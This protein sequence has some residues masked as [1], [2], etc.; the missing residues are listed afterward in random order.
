M[1]PGMSDGGHLSWGGGG[2]DHLAGR[3]RRGRGRWPPSWRYWDEVESWHW[4]ICGRRETS[5]LQTYFSLF[6]WEN[7]PWMDVTGWATDLIFWCTSLTKDFYIYLSA[8]RRSRWIC[9]F[10]CLPFL[11]NNSRSKTRGKSFGRKCIL[12]LELYWRLLGL[13]LMGRE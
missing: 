1:R 7:Q 4:S 12:Y 9:S 13:E 10:S 2:G 3:R 6:W 8:V 5:S 11:L